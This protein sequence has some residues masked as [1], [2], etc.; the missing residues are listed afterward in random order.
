MQSA[1]LM[2]LQCSLCFQHTSNLRHS[3]DK[4]R[5]YMGPV[6]KVILATPWE[7]APLITSHPA[8]QAA[9]PP[10][11]AARGARPERACIHVETPFREAGSGMKF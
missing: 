8:F 7:M 5:V 6:P 1:A 4:P 3:Y 9:L 11:G 10:W 2:L